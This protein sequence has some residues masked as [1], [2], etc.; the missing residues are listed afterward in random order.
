MCWKIK[1]HN[2]NSSLK[3]PKTLS[4]NQRHKENEVTEKDFSKNQSRPLGKSCDRFQLFL[5]FLLPKGEGH[6]F[7]PG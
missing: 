7:K 5:V 6:K 2:S 3:P 1:E 4:L